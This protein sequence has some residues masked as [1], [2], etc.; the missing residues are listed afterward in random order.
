MDKKPVT[1]SKFK[2]VT[3]VIDSG[4]T[5][6]DVQVLSDHFISKRK[7]ELFKRIK[8]TTVIKLIE[9]N[10]NT[11]SIYNLADETNNQEE[12]PDVKDPKQDENQSVYSHHTGLTNVTSASVKTT[13]TA[14]T[15][16]TEMLGNLVRNTE[17]NFCHI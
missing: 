9:E 8:N 10:N 1:S 4:K 14:V 16:A 7:N 3:K 12:K 17:V 2:D 6:K 11:E 13:I 15:Y 5:I